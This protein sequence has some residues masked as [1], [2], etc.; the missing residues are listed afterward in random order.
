MPE[1]IAGNHSGAKRLVSVDL[2]PDSSDGMSWWPGT[3]TGGG[4]GG[5][6]ASVLYDETPQGEAV[7]HDD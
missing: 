2:T 7:E 6:D 5:P 4:G 3:G 1:V